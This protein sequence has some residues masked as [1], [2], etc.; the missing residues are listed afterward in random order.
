[1]GKIKN[2]TSKIFG[3]LK[4]IGFVKVHNNLALWECIC[5]LCQNKINVSSSDLTFGNKKSCGCSSKEI[6][7]KTNLDRYNCNNVMQDPIIATHNAKNQNNS[8]VLVNWETMEEVVC[9][10]SFEK[11]V[12][13]YLNENKIRYKWQHKTFSMTLSNGI[14][15]TY[16]PDL[17]L[18]GKRNPRVE[19]KGYF[20]KDAEEKW[21]IFNKIIKP[22]SELWDEEKL[23][24]MGIL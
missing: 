5:G 2:L 21:K 10:G 12:V 8:F 11:N 6:R 9:V 22:N 18:I 3:H 17:Y 14:I 4:V 7:E 19:I 20:R 24:S 15:T 13:N 1:M 23:K 16:R